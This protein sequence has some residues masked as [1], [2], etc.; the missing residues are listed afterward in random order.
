MAE[1]SPAALHKLLRAKAIEQAL[2]GDAGLLRLLLCEIEAARQVE[3]ERLTIVVQGVCPR[4]GPWM[5]D[6]EAAGHEVR[7]AALAA[8]DGELAARGE[9][10]PPAPSAGQDA[11]G[12]V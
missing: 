2:A 4:C 3:A 7:A 6:A 8:I 9:G 11:R 5:V 1:L 10:P 12:G